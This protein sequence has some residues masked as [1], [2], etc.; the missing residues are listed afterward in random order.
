MA[1]EPFPI[2]VGLTGKRALDGKDEVVA[3]ALTA[4]FQAMDTAFPHSPKVLVT[5]LA[6]GADTVATRVAL[7]RA[8]WRA[9]GLLPYSRHAYRASFSTDAARY[10]FDALLADPQLHCHELPPLRPDGADRTGSHGP[11]YEQL[12]LWLAEHATI[13][14]GV[15]PAAEGEGRLGGSARVIANRCRGEPDAAGEA[16]LAR[17]TAIAPAPLTL[18]RSCRPI[19]CPAAAWLGQRP[20]GQAVRSRP[21]YPPPH[22]SPC[23]R[24]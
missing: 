4:V 24:D 7:G 19:A 17:S 10:A 1:A 12:G 20:G 16:I 2:L 6:E 15:L 8:G 14:V 11:E 21:D 22:G 3:E 18:F 9:I 13:L 5:G 23:G